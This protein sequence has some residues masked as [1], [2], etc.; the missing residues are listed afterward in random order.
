MGKKR[1]TQD[2]LWI[3]RKEM[4]EDWGG[5]KEEES[6]TNPLKKLPFYC[7][8]LSFTPFHDPVCLIDGTIFDIVN[9]LPY[10]KKF[11][12]NPITGLPLK[13]TD[14]IK[15]HFYKNQEGEFHCPVTYKVFTEHTVIIAI[16][17]TGNVYSYEAFEELNKNQAVV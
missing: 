9:I 1:H 11:K 15:L 4:V 12:K 7:C 8:S 14:L 17:E 16:K 6:R 10:I 3:T 2:K 13:V 5:K